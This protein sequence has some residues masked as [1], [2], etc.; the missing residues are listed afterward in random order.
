MLGRADD[1]LARHPWALGISTFACALGVTRVFNPDRPVL[2]WLLNTAWYTF[3]A[4][5]FMIWLQRR[6]QRQLGDDR[7]DLR[8]LERLL[9]RGEMPRSEPERQAMPRLIEQTLHRQRHL[10]WIIPLFACLVFGIAT[11]AL[12]TGDLRHGLLLGGLGLALCGWFLYGAWR[13]RRNA[14]RLTAQLEKPAMA[15]GRS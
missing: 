12:V 4:V 7:V 1:W 13:T 9:W 11:L 3:I 5:G 10:K 8:R 14:R 2:G 15:A 6:R